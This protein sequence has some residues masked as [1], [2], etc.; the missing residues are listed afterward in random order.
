M[1]DWDEE[2]VAHIAQHGVKPEEAEEALLNDPVDVERQTRWG[3]ER[4]LQVGVTKAMRF[5][6]LVTTWRGEAMRVVTAYP[7]T[8]MQRE[9][10]MR[11]KGG[12]GN[13]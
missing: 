8:P 1:F 5:L 6:G 2:N 4:V 12:K 11:M 3:E 10:F 7:A 9:F 13:E